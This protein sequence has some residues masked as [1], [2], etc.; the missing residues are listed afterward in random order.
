MAGIPVNRRHSYE[1]VFFEQNMSV[2]QGL[3]FPLKK[4]S[5][6]NGHADLD[7]DV[8]LFGAPRRGPDTRSISYVAGDK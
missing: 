6:T 4:T 3:T 1:N 5:F 8:H 7:D 2:L